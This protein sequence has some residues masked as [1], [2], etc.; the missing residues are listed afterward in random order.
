MKKILSQVSPKKSFL[1]LIPG[2]IVIFIMLIFLRTPRLERNWIEDISRLSHA[3]MENDHQF[4]LHTIRDWSYSDTAPVKKNYFDRTYDLKN[5]ESLWLYVQPL[6]LGGRVAHT[7][8]VFEFKGEKQEDYLGIS[9]ET[10][11]EIGEEYS[12]FAGLFRNFELN[13][14]WATER[15]LVKRR[16]VMLDYPLQRYKIKA[17][18]TVMQ[19]LLKKLLQTT[20]SL[21]QTPQWYNTLLDNCTNELLESVNKV[22][23]NT[24]PLHYSFFLTG[25]VD[26]YLNQLGYIDTTEPMLNITGDLLTTNAL[27]SEAARYNRGESIL[28]KE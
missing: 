2:A 23:L 16:A 24:I 27:Q 3:T 11:R 14:T 5:M 17:P 25:F 15:D 22:Y 19:E 9:I 26:D 13:Y 12:A 21:A 7:F 18:K 4:T 1:L 10:R 6:A 20:N 8:L 28:Q